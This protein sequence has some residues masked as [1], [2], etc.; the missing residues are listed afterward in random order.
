MFHT[1]VTTRSGNEV[2]FDRAS[3]LMD[4]DLLDEAIV[5]APVGLPDRAALVW[6]HYC[7]AH[8]ERYG[9]PFA[10]D[11]DPQWDR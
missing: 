9:E 11:D 2:D 6:K 3:Y 7:D 4:R 1:Y 8:L 10:P 5:A